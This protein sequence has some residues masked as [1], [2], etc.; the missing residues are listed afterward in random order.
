LALCLTAL[1]CWIK[2]FQSANRHWPWLL[3]SAVLGVSAYFAKQNALALPIVLLAF[4]L[5]HTRF[6]EIPIIHRHKILFLLGI[7]VAGF[8][9]WYLG[10]DGRQIFLEK[11][12]IALGRMNYF[13]PCSEAVYLQMV[14][15]SW[16]FSFS[17]LLVPTGLSLEYQ[18]PA[19]EGWLDPWVLGAVL[20]TVI[21][22]AGTIAAWNRSP[23]AFVF[24]VW[25]AAFWLPTSNLWPLTN[26][27]AADRYLYAPSVGFFVLVSMAVFRSPRKSMLAGVS[28]IIAIAVLS[29]LTWKQNAVW[30][31]P[32][33][34]WQHAAAVNPQSTTA[35]NNLGRCHYRKGDYPKAIELF[36]R[37]IQSN[38]Y[39]ASPYFNLGLAYDKIDKPDLSRRYY[40]RFTAMKDPRYFDLSAR[41]TTH[42]EN[43]SDA[44]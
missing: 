14:A 32:C 35:L 42:L 38:P 19:P 4:L 9:T 17:K 18:Y 40:L 1:I 31:T 27:L 12:R 33:S 20:L 8:L 10:F 30:K 25:L 41:V 28:V 21:W 29:T 39:N 22:A 5:V 16:L 37:S 36:L 44:P 26:R 6:K 43:L 11:C 24:L 34:L 13:G 15:K 7:G 23:M 3:S 2:G